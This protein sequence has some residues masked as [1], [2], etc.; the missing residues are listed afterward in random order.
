M[1]VAIHYPDSWNE[2]AIDLR[3]SIP[4]GGDKGVEWHLVKEP[5]E[6]HPSEVEVVI[7]DDE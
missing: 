6:T 7:E 2:F 5:P 4:K 3:V 1:K